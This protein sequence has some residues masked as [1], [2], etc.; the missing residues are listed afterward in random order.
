MWKLEATLSDSQESESGRLKYGRTGDTRETSMGRA[1]N[2]RGRAAAGVSSTC[3][4]R[5]FKIRQ[6]T[7]IKMLN[8]NKSWQQKQNG[9]HRSLMIR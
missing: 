1:E 9:K 7:T 5:N 4:D 2:Q 3:N 8:R 6:E